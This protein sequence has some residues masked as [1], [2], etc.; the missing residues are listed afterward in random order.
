M[1][2]NKMLQHATQNWLKMPYNWSINQNL[3]IKFTAC[4]QRGTVNPDYLSYFKPI[5]EFYLQDA[6][7]QNN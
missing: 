2:W 4:K 1:L 6:I 7:Q 3:N 5:C